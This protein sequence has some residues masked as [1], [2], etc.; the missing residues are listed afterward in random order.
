MEL[1]VERLVEKGRVIVKKAYCDWSRYREYK[2]GLHEL[3]ID[4]IEVPQRKVGGKNSADIRMVVDAI[5]VCYEKPHLDVFVVASGDSDFSPL[6]NKLREMNKEVIGVGLKGSTSKLL[7]ECC[8]QFIFYEDLV[9]HTSKRRVRT[10][11]SGEEGGV[12]IPGRLKQLPEK[13]AKAFTYVLDAIG[14]LLRENKETLW[15]SMIKQ[16]IKRKHPSFDENYHGYSTF[17]RLLE[18][19]QKE[20]LLK[21][22]R[23]EASGGYI[24]TAVAEDLL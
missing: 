16:T 8:D 19:A 24:V 22:K 17:S 4:L 23:D 10:K 6:V 2:N 18:D 11:S 7:V 9:R 12:A 20:A 1:I 15:G 21:L 5:E 13:K 3:A 14:G